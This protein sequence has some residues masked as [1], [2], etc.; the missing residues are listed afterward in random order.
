[1]Q[2]KEGNYTPK[3]AAYDIAICWLYNAYAEHT[4]DIARYDDRPSVQ[5][6]IKRQIAKLHN[7]LIRKTTLDGIELDEELTELKY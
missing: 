5:K 4:N 3:E 1:M 6:E 7:K 2:T